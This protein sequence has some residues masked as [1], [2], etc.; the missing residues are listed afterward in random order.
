MSGVSTR[1]KI[2]HYVRDRLLQGHPPTIREVQ[3]AFGFKAVESARGHLEALVDEGRLVK[4][5][6]KARGYALPT[7]FPPVSQVPVL[8]TVQAGALA[9][10]LQ[11]PEG[12]VPVES[13]YPVDELFALWVRGQSMRD[14]GILPGDLVITR[15][16]PQANQNEIVVALVEDEATVK[17]FRLRNGRVELHPEN[18][19]FEVLR[20]ER[21]EILGKVV[22]VRRWL[23]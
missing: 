14:A 21:V 19:D 3:R 17:R 5:P 4:Q 2:Y 23:D 8:G 12:Y 11:E 10:A 1:D 16:Q 22:E 13:R 6:G 15:R 9:L 20:P 7:S 18:P